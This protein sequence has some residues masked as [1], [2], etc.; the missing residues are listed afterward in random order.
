MVNPMEIPGVGPRNLRKLVEKG[1]GGV[2]ELKQSYKDKCLSDWSNKSFTTL[3]QILQDLLPLD[4][5]LP[6]DNYE[7]K[8]IIKDLGLGYEK[9]HACSNDCMLFWKE[10]ALDEACS[11]CGASRWKKSKG[12]ES[13]DE[14]Q[15]DTDALSKRKKK[16]AKILW[17]FPLKPRLQ[18]LFMSSK[19]TAYMKWH[20]EGR[21]EDGLMR[22]PADSQ[23]W[24]MFNSQHVEFSSDPRNVRLGLSSDGFNPYG[25]MSTAHSTWPVILFSYNFPPWMCMK[26]SSFMLS[27]LIPGPFSPGNDIDVEICS[28]VLNVEDLEHLEKKI[29]VTLCQLEKIFPPSFFTVMVHL[30]THLATEAK[31][32]GPVHYRW[33]YPIER[34]LARLKSHVRNKAHIEGSIAKGNSEHSI[35]AVL[36]IALDRKSWIQAHRYV[37]FNCDEVIPFHKVHQDHIKTQTHPRHVTNDLIHKIHMETFCDWLREYVFEMTVAEREKLSHKMR[38]LAQG[39]NIEARRLKRYVT[40]DFKFRIKGCD[41]NKTT[42]NSGVSVVTEG[43]TSYY[44]VLTDIIELNYF[45]NFSDE[46][47]IIASQASQVFYVEDERHKDWVVVKARDIYD[48]GIGVLYEED[49]YCENVPYNITIDDAYDDVNDNLNCSRA[50]VEGI[51]VDTLSIVEENFTD[52]ECQ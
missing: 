46:P 28:K 26:R 44:G 21:T 43:D 24:K 48:A 6:K 36:N 47:F 38:W 51:T 45:D 7:A 22:H 16:G 11:V 29:A 19:I 5:K 35:G 40:N 1:I 27:L 41:K 17:W 2:A 20:A 9:I 18:R 34:Y 8:K 10:N 37:L 25:H 13:E 42:Q 12:E 52:D 33:M 4:A 50:D 3:F 31:I 14:V 15:D 39:P 30:L 49:N 23:A 32:A